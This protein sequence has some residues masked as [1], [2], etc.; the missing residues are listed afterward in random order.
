[1]ILA[2][3]ML[4][5]ERRNDRMILRVVSILFLMSIAYCPMAQTEAKINM[6]IE[7]LALHVV[8]DSLA[9]DRIA[10]SQL[11]KKSLLNQLT[12]RKSAKNP[13]RELTAVSVTDSGDDVFRIFSW[14]LFISPDKYRHEAII[15]FMDG[16][17]PPI[18]LSDKSDDI[19]YPDRKELTVENWF[20]ALYYNIIPFKLKGKVK[21]LLFG[22]DSATRAENCKIVDILNIDKRG[23]LTFGAPL[24]ES[25]V[26]GIK[27]TAYR[28]F[29]TIKI[30]RQS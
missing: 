21:Y 11:L 15:Q 26:Q 20:G 27:K 24:F 7:E 16:E 25:E 10:A 29:H 9:D 2:L 14:Q 4:L 12:E 13:F 8:N 6:E 17:R 1:M 19:R 23:E 30:P 22:F 3:D 28:H 5:S 18:A